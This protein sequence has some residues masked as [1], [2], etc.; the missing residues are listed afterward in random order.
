MKGRTG[1]GINSTCGGKFTEGGM[2]CSAWNGNIITPSIP[3]LVSVNKK[4][5]SQVRR[6]SELCYGE[7]LEGQE[8][9]V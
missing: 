9:T 5:I 7:K 2:V 6:P 1:E 8:R 4:C 3:V